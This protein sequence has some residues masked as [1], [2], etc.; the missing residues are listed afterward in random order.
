MAERP[1]CL[2]RATIFRVWATHF[3]FSLVSGVSLQRRTGCSILNAPVDDPEKTRIRQEMTSGDGSLCRAGGDQVPAGQ[4]ESRDGQGE[5]A[6]LKLLCIGRVKVR[7]IG[8]KILHPSF[9][10]RKNF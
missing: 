6:R 10:S 2:S 1:G 9:R 3:R 4:G 7:Q 8:Q 5:A